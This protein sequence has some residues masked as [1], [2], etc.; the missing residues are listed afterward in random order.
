M[1][2]ALPLDPDARRSQLLATA[3]LVFARSGYH[4]TSVADIIQEAGVAR[5]TFYNYFESKRAVFQAVLDALTEDLAA[6][7]TPVDPEGDIPAQL[8]GTLHRNLRVITREHDIGRLLFADAVG[9]DAEGDEALRAFYGFATA[10]ISRA[11]RRGQGMGLVRPGDVDL[12]A[13]CL[14]GMVK[15]PLFQSWLHNEPLDADGLV[16]TMLGLVMGGV[17]A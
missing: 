8:R 6:A 16:D 14:L 5:G 13:R 15:E 2:R 17:W 9:L 12:T 7:V 11:L 3:R 10:R 4:A 1:P